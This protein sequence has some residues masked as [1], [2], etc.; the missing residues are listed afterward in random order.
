MDKFKK[1]DVAFHKA[2]HKRCVIKGPGIKGSLLVT[3]V[4]DETKSYQ[5]EELW[6]EQE[7]NQRNAN[8]M[9]QASNPNLDPFE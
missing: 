7:W 2:T 5:P 3:T 9:A 1:G 8:L 6:T 4:D